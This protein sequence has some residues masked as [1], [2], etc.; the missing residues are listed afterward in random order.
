MSLKLIND[1]IYRHKVL[2]VNYTTYNV[3]REQ[4]SLNPRTHGDIM[5]LSV[6]DT[7]PYWYA[8]I[9][10]IFHAMVL[11]IGPKSKSQEP[12]KNGISFRSVVW[13]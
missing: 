10:G 9:I 8:R 2:R 1:R 5:V 3:R 13:A 7:H 12:K 6:D 11:Q 4:D